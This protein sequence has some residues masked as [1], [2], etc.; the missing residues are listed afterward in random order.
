MIAKKR[1]SIVS[2]EN[3]LQLIEEHDAKSRTHSHFNA[4]GLLNDSESG[5]LV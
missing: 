4:R 1:T 5:S 3:R 2:T